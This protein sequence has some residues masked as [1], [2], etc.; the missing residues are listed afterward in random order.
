MK[1]NSPALLFIGLITLLV[2]ACSKKDSVPDAGGNTLAKIEFLDANQQSTGSLLF[3]YDGQ[4][5]LTEIANSSGTKETFTYNVQGRLVTYTVPS[6]L[7]YNYTYDANGRI[8]SRTGT[9]ILPNLLLDDYIYTYDA[10]GR[11]ITDSVYTLGNLVA[12]SNYQYD[13]NNNVSGYQHFTKN[14]ATFTTDGMVTTQYDNKISPYGQYGSLLFYTQGDFSYLSK[15]NIVSQAIGQTII[16]P[17]NY[18]TYKYY[19][20]G[21]LRSRANTG[22]NSNTAIYTYKKP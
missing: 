12:Y 1:I 22:V 2:T 10:S 15:A 18:Y 8:I 9:P 6:I 21:L 16:T 4:N 19:S 17:S 7:I 14:G 20:N 5:R 13:N 11:V 3:T